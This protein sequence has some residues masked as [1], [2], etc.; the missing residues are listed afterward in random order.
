MRYVIMPCGGQD[1]R[2]QV[3]KRQVYQYFNGSHQ[4]K[5]QEASGWS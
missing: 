4:G 3:G 1:I 5:V 2:M